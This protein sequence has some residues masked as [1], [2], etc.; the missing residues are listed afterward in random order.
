MKKL[1]LLVFLSGFCYAQSSI[2]SPYLLNPEK[3]IGYVDSCA[4]FWNK[5]YDSSLGGFYTNIDRYGNLISSWGTN[6]NTLSEARDAY[7]YVRAFMMTGNETYLSYARNALDF[8]YRHAWDNTNT[9]WFTNLD[10]YGNPVNS[11]ENKDAFNQHYALLG[12]TAYFEATADTLDLSW[13]MKGYR[14]N[15]QKLWDKRSDYEGYYDNVTYNWTS[16]NGKSFNATVDAI[17]TH[18]LYLYLLTGDAQYKDKLLKITDNMMKYLVGSMD[19]QKTGFV[20]EFDSN[21]NWDNSQKMT[22][23]GHVLK[24]A[25]CLGRV[26]QISPDTAYISAA[27]K[28]IKSVLDKGYDHQYGGP[29][30]DFDRTTGQMLMWNADTAK[31]WWQMEQAVTAGLELYD[32]TKDDEYLRMADE[33]LDFF[34]K[35]FVDHQYGEV[36]SDRTR[37]G[38]RVPQWG[39]EKGSSGKAAYHSTELGYYVYL[40]GNLFYRKEPVSLYYYFKPDSGEREIPLY[41]LA[42]QDSRLKIKSVTLNGDA[43]SNFTSTGRRLRIPAGVGG[44]FKVT[45]ELNDISSV[46]K[47]EITRPETFSLSQNYPNP[48]NPVTR[49][50]YSVGAQASHVSLRVYD[51]LGNLAATLVSEVKNPGQYEASFDGNA[52][53]SGIYFCRLQSGNNI[54]TIKM[55]LLK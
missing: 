50:R 37:Y 54:K 41:P 20:E 48:F 26:Y 22:I 13:L 39:E 3:A 34:M 29:Y 16:K 47:E 1:L 25:W 42:I 14:N 51:V 45:F 15:E 17:T 21:W 31:A 49:I 52:F 55:T 2:R 4:R 23:M 46:T 53:A 43:Y 7:G 8:M 6:K 38:K 35:Y 19:A 18:I 12:I 40:Y 30:K 33:S 9:G 44:K 5:A 27:K 36:Y 28:L 10:K 32:I 24:T 11:K